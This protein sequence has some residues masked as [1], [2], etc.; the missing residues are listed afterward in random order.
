M[1][2]GGSSGLR[3]RLANLG[4]VLSDC[5]TTNAKKTRRR[6]FSL[7]LAFGMLEVPI[8]WPQRTVRKQTS[9]SW[10][11]HDVELRGK[12][13]PYASASQ[14]PSI[15]LDVLANGTFVRHTKLFRMSCGHGWGGTFPG[16]GSCLGAVQGAFESG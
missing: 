3:S 11:V 9:L 15:V 1:T 12:E 2:G 5:R 6:T 7:D 10:W 13:Q 16:N 14:G 8:L 4:C